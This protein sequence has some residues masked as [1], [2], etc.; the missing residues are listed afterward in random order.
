MLLQFVEAVPEADDLLHPGQVHAEFLRQAPDL[1]QLLDVSLRIEPRLARA[2][3]WF[4]QALTLVQA[5]RLRMHVDEFGSHAD[6]VEGLVLVDGALVV[7]RSAFLILGLV[8]RNVICIVAA[9][10]GSGRRQQL[11]DT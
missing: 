11:V 8:R 5:Q 2:A 10:A 3:A 7:H 1:A 4:Y 9:T 6:D